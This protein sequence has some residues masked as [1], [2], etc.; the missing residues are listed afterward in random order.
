MA[1]AN[2]TAFQRGVERKLRTTFAGYDALWRWS[3][4]DPEAFWREVWDDGEVIGDR[5][6]RVLVDG[7]RMPGA[8]FFPDATLNYAENLLERRPHDD[9]GDALVFRG[10]DKVRARW[11]HAKLH[12]TVSRLAKVFDA[13]DLASGDRVILRGAT[14]VADGQAVQVMP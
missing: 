13:I 1:A 10:E 6:S 8:R 2:I 14:I 4:D 11:S 12:A 9:A 3:I 7:D 5:G